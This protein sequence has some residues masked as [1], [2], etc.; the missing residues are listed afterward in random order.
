MIITVIGATGNLGRQ[1]LTKGLERGHSVRAISRSIESTGADLN[2]AIE[3]FPGSDST[4]EVMAQAFTGVDVVL[5][6]FPPSLAN[7]ADYSNQLT[8]VL[9]AAK[10]AGVPRVIGL[11]GSA[12]TMTSKGIHLVDT[13]YFGETARNFY[14]GVHAAWDSYRNERDYPWVAFVP[15]ARMQNH[16]PELGHYRTRTDEQLVT[17]DDDSWHFFEV[18]QISY[19]DLAAAM[20]DE[21]ERPMHNHAF[22]TVGY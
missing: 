8:R 21:A 11:V 13:D 16:M 2:P 6:V 12:G 14:Q 18:S 15:A 9:E 20:L 17:T 10:S 7:P 5:S 22:V 19:P 4:P 3:R 1:L